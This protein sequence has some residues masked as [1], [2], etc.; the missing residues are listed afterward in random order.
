MLVRPAARTAPPATRRRAGTAAVAAAAA[1]ALTL[2]ACTGDDK[3]DDATPTALTLDLTATYPSAIEQGIATI[4]SQ[5]VDAGLGVVQADGSVLVT[6]ATD[7][8][9]DDS[10][11]LLDLTTG[12]VDWLVEET[13]P[14]GMVVVPGQ[15]TPQWVTWSLEPDAGDA[16]EA[17]AAIEETGGFV[18]ALDRTTGE[19]V[20]LADASGDAG[21]PPGTFNALVAIQGDN[22][23]WEGLDADD[24]SAV[25]TRPLDGSAPA[26]VVAKDAWEVAW[27]ACSSPARLTVTRYDESD[28]VLRS[29]VAADG[30]LA[31]DI[32]LSVPSREDRITEAECGT[33]VVESPYSEEFESELDALAGEGG[34]VDGEAGQ[35]GDAGDGGAGAEGEADDAAGDAGE[36]SA[37]GGA[38]EDPATPQPGDLVELRDGDTVVTFT[39]NGSGTIS[40]VRLD[41]TW[42]VLGLVTD[43]EGGGK[44]FLFHRASRQLYALPDTAL[45]M[46]DLHNGHLVLGSAPLDDGETITQVATLTPPA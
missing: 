5:D 41:P 6:G 28:E 20:V 43:E 18:F 27:E 7:G 42:M 38:T 44:Q 12:E 40:G 36:G 26:T 37:E 16:A 11:G 19:R 13:L 17:H 3:P 31:E 45:M 29:V 14:A 2:S 21:L 25:Y 22:A 4:V 10:V 1:L 34:D 24:A 33:A 30:T 35:A 46:V 32:A 9:Y 8:E 39:A 15:V 23:F